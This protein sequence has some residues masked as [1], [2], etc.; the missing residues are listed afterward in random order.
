VHYLK[1]IGVLISFLLVTNIFLM[2]NEI[3]GFSESINIAG[4]QRML[5]QKMLKD[6]AMIGM[7]NNFGN[8]KEDILS[9]ITEFES[10]LQM[11]KKFNTET[12][13]KI[14]LDEVEKI[15]Q[16]VKII[17]E[18]EPNINKIKTL[19][20]D[21]DLLLTKSND[22]VIL[23]V[24]QSKM[25]KNEIINLAGRQRMFSQRMASLYMLKVWGVDDVD[26]KTKMT[27]TM[28]TFK[29]S[30]DK[31]IEAKETNEEIM[32]HLKKVKKAFLFFE[33]MNRSNSKFIPALIYRKSNEIL[34]EMDKATNLYTKISK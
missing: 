28:E 7:K 8:P 4:K 32:V 5:T 2:G 34:N 19:Q 6:Y 17:L 10:Q 21:L 22:V 27:K 13:T 14:A 16:T 9:V 18:E 26:F 31:L 25:S 20:E 33:I 11:L 3:N 24:K 15:W 1:Q 23:L 30:L 12:K 29:E